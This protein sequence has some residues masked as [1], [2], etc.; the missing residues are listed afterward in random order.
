MSRK[1]PGPL[2]DTSEMVEVLGDIL[3]TS[4]DSSKARLFAKF[5]QWVNQVQEEENAVDL[6][7][8]F[9][10]FVELAQ[11]SADVQ[12]IGPVGGRGRVFYIKTPTGGL[13]QVTAP[14]EG[15]DAL[16][17]DIPSLV[18]T[19]SVVCRDLK[20]DIGKRMVT[21]LVFVSLESVRAFADGTQDRTH[22]VWCMISKH[23]TELAA[24]LMWIRSSK[25]AVLLSPADLTRK[26]RQLGGAKTFGEPV[27][28]WLRGV[29]W[30]KSSEA[31][32]SV[33]VGRESISRSVLLEAGGAE[34]K[35]VSTVCS[36]EIYRD[37]SLLG[38]AD[39]LNPMPRLPVTLWLEADVNEEKIRVELDI[40]AMDALGFET[41]RVLSAN[42]DALCEAEGTFEDESPVVVLGM[43]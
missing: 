22:S 28:A 9:K 3:V 10:S 30:R 17:S 39:G 14:P 12:I 15:R 32:V 31:A 24:W 5:M 21:P 4:N 7:L 34:F 25:G 23:V 29:K 20:L 2:R 26:L 33:D 11:K 27:M 19:L 13:Q 37:A 43:A 40:E 18:E 36:V 6:N 1:R 16:V 42:I 38:D 41:S 35:E 8:A